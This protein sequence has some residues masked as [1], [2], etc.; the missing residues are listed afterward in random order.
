M[1]SQMTRTLAVACRYGITSTVMVASL[2]SGNAC[3]AQ[4]IRVAAPRSGASNADSVF[5]TSPAGSPVPNATVPQ[6]A[7][8][9][10][11][12]KSQEE[13]RKQRRLQKLQ[14]TQFDRRPSTILKAWTEEGKP[15][16]DA[17]TKTS[18]KSEP[19]DC[20]IG[21]RAEAVRVGGG[22]ETWSGKT[23]SQRRAG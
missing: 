12:K 20:N 6:Q 8:P 15:K 1:K 23:G 17:A 4:V 10:D 18:E 11:A 14:Q 5:V 21:R 2:C 13:Q 7:N 9:G 16:K 22:P 3:H 19:A